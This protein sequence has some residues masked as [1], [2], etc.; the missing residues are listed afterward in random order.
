MTVA[1]STDQA[2]TLGFRAKRLRCFQGLTKQGLADTAGVSK[3]DVDILEHDLS[4]RPDAKRALL[5]TL[6]FEDMIIKR[7][8]SGN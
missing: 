5:R 1:H 3:E 2:L 6:G 7:L 4:L 8:L